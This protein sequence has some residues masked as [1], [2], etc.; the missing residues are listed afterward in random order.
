MAYKKLTLNDLPPPLKR[1]RAFTYQNL[2]EIIK[3]AF[4]ITTFVK[5]EACTNAFQKSTRAYLDS[6]KVQSVES[7]KLYNGK[8]KELN[9]TTYFQTGT[10]SNYIDL[11]RPLEV[12][13]SIDISYKIKPADSDLLKNMLDVVYLRAEVYE[14]VINLLYN[15]C[16]ASK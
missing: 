3:K 8:G 12:G 4:D 10:Y 15:H 11:D 14:K 5:T 2:N 9:F 6:T 7:V 13:E 16:L 1:N